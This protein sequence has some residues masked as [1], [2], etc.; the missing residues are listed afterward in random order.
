MDF[1]HVAEASAEVFCREFVAPVGIPYGVAYEIPTPCHSLWS[2]QKKA[3]APIPH[4]VYVGCEREWLQRFNDV[5]NIFEEHV[6]KAFIH[7]Y[8]LPPKV[9]D[10]LETPGRDAGAGPAWP[11]HAQAALLSMARPPK[12]LNTGQ[13][14]WSVAFSVSALESNSLAGI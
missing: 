9:G 11:Y 4:P 13:T 7:I 5:R 8:L 1:D 12:Y 10:R 2:E 6:K 3:P 14:V